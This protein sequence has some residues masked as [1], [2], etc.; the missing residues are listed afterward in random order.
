MS[1][2]PSVSNQS[3]KPQAERLDPYRTLPEPSTSYIRLR[4]QLC[5][6]ENVYRIVRLPLSYTFANL[7]TLI[8]FLFGWNGSHLHESHVYS[9][10]RM[11]SNETEPG[12]MSKYGIVPPLPEWIEPDDEREVYFWGLE[13]PDCAIYNVVPQQR[14]RPS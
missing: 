7:H 3:S 6:F 14:V 10:V 1:S 8:L 11:S 2:K 12:R 4:F 9:H 5:G 13:H